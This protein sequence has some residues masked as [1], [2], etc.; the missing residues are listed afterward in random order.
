M[1]GLDAIGLDDSL[2]LYQRFGVEASYLFSLCCSH[3][4]LMLD[5]LV[6]SSVRACDHGAA[7]DD[8]RYVLLGKL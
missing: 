6:P 8:G 5:D 1:D 7:A 3:P 2:P 4:F